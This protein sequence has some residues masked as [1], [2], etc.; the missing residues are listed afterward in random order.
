[1]LLLFA[2]T[3]HK[4]LGCDQLRSP[5]PPSSTL[6]TSGLLL[7]PTLSPAYLKPLAAS[8]QLPSPPFPGGSGRSTLG[9]ISLDP[10][11]LAPAVGFALSDGRSPPRQP[12]PPA[13]SL[14]LFGPRATPRN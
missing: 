9:A 14:H 10:S 7:M 6:M 1:M 13:P 2:C 5:R 3:F 12:Q 4:S 8:R 11:S